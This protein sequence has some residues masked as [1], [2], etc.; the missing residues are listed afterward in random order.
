MRILL[1]GGTGYVGSYLI[2]TLERQGHE[3]ALLVRRE[4]DVTPATIA[5]PYSGLRALHEFCFTW[6]PKAVIHLAADVRKGSDIPCVEGLTAANILLPLHMASAANALGGAFFINVS[7]FSTHSDAGQYHPQTL[8]AATKRACEDLLAYY[9][10]SEHLT[11]CNL[12]FYDVYGPQQPHARFLNEAVA[13]VVSQTPFSM[14]RGEQDICF[15]HV[16][17]AADAI[18]H[19]LNNKERFKQGDE[20]T[21]CVYGPEVFLLKTV[22]ER[23]SVALKRPCPLVQHDRPYRKNEIMRFAPRYPL[24]PDWKPRVHFADGV[25]AFVECA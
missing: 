22:P 4:V 3:V 20:N 11:V 15:L 14:T 2:R 19:C 1:S 5:V 8:Y 10:Q 17:D 18:A 12:I 23:I 13:S 21:F 24:P 16:T 6:R 9:N 7:T 25:K